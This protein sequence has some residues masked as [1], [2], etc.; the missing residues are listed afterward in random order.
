MA[1]ELSSMSE[2]LLRLLKGLQE[3]SERDTA[4]AT[5]CMRTNFKNMSSKNTIILKRNAYVY[6]VVTLSWIEFDIAAEH[7]KII[8]SNPHHQLHQIE[9]DLSRY[10]HCIDGL[11]PRCQWISW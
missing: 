7:W 9:H 11:W 6:L 1:Q 5:V 8:L 10:F 4:E 3:A 2:E